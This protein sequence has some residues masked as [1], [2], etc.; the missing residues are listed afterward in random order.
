L[1]IFIISF[2]AAK[3]VKGFFEE[4]KQL[5]LLP[6]ATTQQKDCRKLPAVF[7]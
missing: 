7:I 4:L 5:V 1:A 2:D 6:F 3:Q